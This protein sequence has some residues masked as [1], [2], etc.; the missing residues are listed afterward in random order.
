MRP[1]RPPATRGEAMS[2]AAVLLALVEAEVVLWIEGS[3]LRYRAPVGRLDAKL[4]SQAVAARPALLVLVQSGA[5]L[6]RSRDAWALGERERFAERAG[7]L[8]FEDGL[9]RQAAEREAERLVRVEHARAF[10]ARAALVV[11]STGAVA[12]R[13]EGV[14]H[15]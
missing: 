10:V 2:P 5:V 4:R 13:P 9:P 3:T 15:R 7:F 12:A 6:P 8:E 1:H 11:P 14:P